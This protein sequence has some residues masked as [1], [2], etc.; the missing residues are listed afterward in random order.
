MINS[1]SLD[2]L[3]PK[4]KALAEQFKKECLAAGF[5]ILIYSTYRD[6]EAQDVIYAQGRTAKGRI[7]TNARGGQSFHNYRVAFD[8]VPM[9]H[10]KPLWD[11]DVIYAKCGRIGESIGLEWAGRWSGKIK[12]TAHMQYTGGLSLADFQKGKTL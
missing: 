7:V 8:W 9:L 6:N 4:V 1:R 10:G 3:H 12:E 2:E 11:N 5:D